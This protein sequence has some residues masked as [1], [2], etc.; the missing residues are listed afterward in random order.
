MFGSAFPSAI[1]LENARPSSQNIG[2][3]AKTLVFYA[4]SQLS[5]IERST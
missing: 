2:S 3:G 5:G 4:A 1:K